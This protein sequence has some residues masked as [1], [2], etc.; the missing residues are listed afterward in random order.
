[1][2]RSLLS[3]M[4]AVTA[5]L[6]PAAASA[7]VAP[8][9]L[10]SGVYDVRRDAGTADAAA[11]TA[12]ARPSLR[13]ALGSAVVLETDPVQGTPRLVM[14]PGGALTRSSDARPREIAL[15]YLRAHPRVFGLDAGDVGGLDVVQQSRYAL[16]LRKVGFA[17]LAAGIPS[18][19]TGLQASFDG[20]G[21][22]LSIAGAPHP[23]LAA[24]V[25]PRPSLSATAALRRLL[26]GVGAPGSVD[27]LSGPLGP[28]RETRFA[29]GGLARLVW[30][31]EQDGARLGWR[32]FAAADSRHVYDAVIDARDGSL[33]FR[34]N[35]VKSAGQALA[36]DTRPGGPGS[37]GVAQLRNF[38]PW[39]S[40]ATQLRGP[41]AWVYSDVD[42]NIY[43]NTITGTLGS[44][45]APDTDAVQIRPGP[46]GDWNFTQTPFDQ[47]SGDGQSCP[48]A[49]GLGACSWDFGGANSWDVNR[50]QGGT[51]LFYYV[52]NFHDHLKNDPSIAFGPAA[53]NFEGA[54]ALH[55]QVLD[56]A[57]TD[58]GRPDSDHLNNANMVTTPD[59]MSPQM[60]MYLFTDEAALSGV[61]VGINDVNGADD[62]AIVYHEY[63]HGLNSRVVCCD[64]D[65]WGQLWGPQAGA[66]DEAWAD[67]YALDYLE[68]LGFIT[69]SAA[70]GEMSFGGYENLEVRTQPMDCPPGGGGSACPGT[71]GGGAGGYTYGDFARIVPL[72]DNGD[73][74]LDGEVHADGEIWASTL[75]DLRTSLIATHGAAE[76]VRR[77][78][79]LVARGQV[80]VPGSPSFLEARNALLAAS[81][82]LGYGEPGCNLIWGVFA[83]RGM[84]SNARTGGNNDTSPVQGFLNPAPA[85]CVP[86]PPPPPP[87]PPAP[88]LVTK[89]SFAG[90]PAKLRVTRRGALTLRFR[91]TPG[92]TA[93]VIFRTQGRPVQTLVRRQVR[94]PASGRVVFKAKLS[95]S[96]LALLRRKR[97]LPVKVSVTVFVRTGQ[98]AAGGRRLT[99]VAAGRR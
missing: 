84:G 61:N 95:R 82:S 32:V 55:A 63:T 35:L 7:A 89:P 1:M 67:W 18:F 27:A 34:R 99:L 24:G 87:P 43:I 75:W 74:V 51:Q 15:R 44:D 23:D 85:A 91:A 94:V 64:V 88:P 38:T 54:D 33:L 11:A 31:A 90:T 17:Q 98:S 60:Q 92:A 66:L 58:L 10:D 22:L 57:N 3:L 79:A 77:A 8:H 65:G 30:F 59:G 73:G 48:Q 4:G 46:G 13:R 41:N 52:N 68:A 76:G 96:G 83:A 36:F 49:S 97:I 62:A 19:D 14:R 9:T 5:A 37:G 50:R 70:A 78:R 93:E 53:G 40:S 26:A 42:D 20:Q 2:R 21:R 80:L 81:S 86:P 6:A 25:E 45:V 69:D 71:S 28:R 56:G 16:G 12:P 39:L 29:G 47:T 72:D